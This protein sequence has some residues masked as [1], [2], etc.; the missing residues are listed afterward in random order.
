MRVLYL[1][2]VVGLVIQTVLAVIAILALAGQRDLVAVLIP[3]V[4]AALPILGAL[5]IPAAL[6]LR[7][8]GRA[9]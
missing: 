8:I 3:A 6:Y 4:Y 1:V 7:W 9:L 2:G 5:P